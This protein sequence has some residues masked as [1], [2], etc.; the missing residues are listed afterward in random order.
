MSEVVALVAARDEADRIRATVAAL[1]SIPLVT[2]IV[3]AD[4][5][6]TDA[7]A[8]E[9]LASGARVFRTP[10]S[11][12]KGGALEAAVDAIAPA[13][14]V[15]LLADGDLAETAASLA[16]IVAAVA[17][18]RADVAIGVVPPGEGG[19]LGLVRRLAGAAI[20]RLGGITVTQPLSGQRALSGA[21]MARIRP[22]ARGFGV[23]TAMTIDAARA[24]LRVMELP[25]EVRHRATYRDVRGFVHRGRQGWHILRAVTSRTFGG[26]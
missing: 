24:G 9:A 16:P 12:G 11:R 3:V 23:E 5:G 7:T 1:R 25:V 18:G 20:R 13:P 15:W 8:A 10:R 4:D 21:A 26:R 6:S 2:G 22:L 17:E 19:G 14:D